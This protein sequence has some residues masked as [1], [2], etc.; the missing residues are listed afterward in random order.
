MQR[1]ISNRV[2]LGQ[3]T[4]PLDD[5]CYSSAIER[6]ASDYTDAGE[7]VKKIRELIRTGKYD[8]DI[9]RCIP[10]VL[11]LVF[12]GMLEDINTKEK[13]ANASY[14]DMEELDFQTLLPDNYYVNPSS[15]YICFYMKIKKSTNEASDIDDDLITVDNFFAHLVKEISVT[16]YGSDKELIPTFSPYEVYQYWDSMLKHLP[17]SALSKLL[18]SKKAIYYNKTS[19]N[20]RVHNGAGETQTAEKRKNATHLHIQE[21]ITKLHM[22]SDESL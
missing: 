20:W 2:F 17:K 14:K 12:Q 7:K 19:L 9:A 5:V 10:G 1:E 11:K 21:R 4:S 18:Y 3:T 8:T 15:I 13:A 22:L 16:K 6:T